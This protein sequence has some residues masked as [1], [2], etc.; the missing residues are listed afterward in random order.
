MKLPRGED[1]IIPEGKIETYCLNVDHVVG[2]P[3]ARVFA[4][5]LGLTSKDV[6]VLRLSLVIAASGEEAVLFKQDRYGDHYR[7]D[8]RLRHASRERTI[9]S[10]WTIRTQG[11]PPYLATAFVLP[12]SYD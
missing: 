5:A 8:F 9:R 10:G 4:S 1:A 7:I 3:K 11:G 2:G 12:F 6:D